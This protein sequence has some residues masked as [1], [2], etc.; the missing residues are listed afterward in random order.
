MLPTAAAAAACLQINCML[1]A[2]SGSVSMRDG[3]RSQISPR[4][5]K[6]D[7]DQHRD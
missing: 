3:Y 4:R 6:T 5:A 7:C 1:T 2:V